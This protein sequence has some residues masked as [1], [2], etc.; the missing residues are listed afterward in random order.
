MLFD[1]SK[2]LIATAVVGLSIITISVWQNRPCDD[3]CRADKLKEFQQQMVKCTA[4]AGGNLRDVREATK[5]VEKLTAQIE[6]AT[7]K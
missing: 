4:Q 7:Q 1:M 6:R 3:R 5:C 2:L